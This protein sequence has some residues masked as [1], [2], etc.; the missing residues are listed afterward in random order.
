MHLHQPDWKSGEWT[1]DG[2]VHARHHPH[3]TDV[4][5]RRWT[6]TGE[7]KPILDSLSFSS[8]YF[9]ILLNSL[10]NMVIFLLLDFC[11]FSTSGTKAM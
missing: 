4:T 9:P 2:G 6:W 7:Q 11:V 1:V 8:S 5:D 10:K 3:W